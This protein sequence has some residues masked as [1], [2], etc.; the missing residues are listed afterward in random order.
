MPRL[1][2]LLLLL[3]PSLAFAQANTIQTNQLIT[4][5]TDY[6]VF[7]TAP[8]LAATGACRLY[9]DGL[10]LYMSCSGGAYSAFATGSGTAAPSNAQYWTGAADGTLSAEKNLGVLST[11]LVLNT[12]GVP[13]AYAG[14]ACTNQFPRSLDASGAATC[15]S[16]ANA[17]LSNSSITIQGAAVALGGT[18]LATSSTP[19]FGGLLIGAT[20]FTNLGTPANG[21]VLYC[22][23]CDPAAAVTC[24]SAGTQ[25]GAFA[26]RTGGNWICV[27]A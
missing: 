22:S 21:T 4:K 1:L 15:A 5:I 9:A 26:F 7:T 2:A 14:T 27:G 17:D 24:T 11:G 18:T 23:D 13:T 3:I 16:V 20:L 8:A 19:T 25:T 10:N 12:A 6:M